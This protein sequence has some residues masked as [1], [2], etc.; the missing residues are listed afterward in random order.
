MNNCSCDAETPEFFHK[1]VNKAR[2][3]KVC[4]EC[5]RNITKGEIYERVCGKWNGDVEVYN[6][7]FHCYSLRELVK[8]SIPCFCSSFGDSRS[9]AREMLVEYSKEIPGFFFKGARLIV[10]ANKIRDKQRNECKTN[11]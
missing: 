2:K 11:K 3:E 6:T 4:C 10:Q 5:K 9:D 7:C 8:D 1:A